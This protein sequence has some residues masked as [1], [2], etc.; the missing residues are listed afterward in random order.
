LD[1]FKVLRNYDKYYED[2]ASGYIPLNV[3]YVATSL[4]SSHYVQEKYNS[5]IFG[6]SRSIFYE[7]QDWESYLPR[8]SS[9]FHFDASGEGLY[10]IEKKVNYI[11]G[12]N[13]AINNV[14][15][16]LDYDTL[17]KIGPKPGRLFTTPPKLVNNNNIID[18]HFESF[19]AFLSPRFF[20]EYFDFL[21]SGAV[22]D[23]MKTIDNRPRN[24]DATT[25]ELQFDYFED[26]INSGRYYTPERLSVFYQRDTSQTYSPVVIREEQKLLLKSMHNSFKKFK[27]EYKIV[28]NPLY[29]QVKLNQ[30]DLAFLINLFGKRNVFDYSGIN[31]YTESYENYYESSHYRPHIAREIMEKIY[32]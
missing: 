27:S 3:D 16:I 23:Y 17:K 1:P 5:F 20:F 29:D 8:N 2:N 7:I 10:G 9:C 24:H 28:I 32:E 18:F 4:F 25:N 14:L 12:V 6:N 19:L 30:Q 31:K 22:K 13:C 15:L 26:M 21:I 11:S